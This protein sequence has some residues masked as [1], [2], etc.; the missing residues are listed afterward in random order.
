MATIDEKAAALDAPE[1]PETPAQTETESDNVQLA[2][3]TRDFTLNLDWLWKPT[4]EGEIDDYVRHPL[5]VRESRAWAQ[6]I[7]GLTGLVG[8]TLSYWWVD[9]LFGFLKLKQEQGEKAA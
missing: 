5:N 8:N 2:N 6:I 1:T 4:G 3:D 7:R 9:V